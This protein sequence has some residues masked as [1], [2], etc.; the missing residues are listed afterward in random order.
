MTLRE[1]LTY[2][3]H[4]WRPKSPQGS[5]SAPTLAV[6]S[7]P[8]AVRPCA[9]QRL[10]VQ[11]SA[12]AVRPHLHRH[13]P[14]H[15]WRFDHGLRRSD[16][17]W[18]IGWRSDCHPRLSDRLTVH[19]TFIACFTN[20]GRARRTTHMTSAAPQTTPTTLHAPH[21]APTSTTPPAPAAAPASKPHLTN[22]L[23]VTEF[24]K[25]TSLLNFVSRQNNG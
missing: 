5:H 8:W 15:S 16:H 19:G 1:Q 4:Y 9:T 21:A 13:R 12:W 2:P 11:P 24:W 18:N 14:Q 23:Q 25:S 3:H 10:V 6:R 17:P 22:G 7:R 20:F